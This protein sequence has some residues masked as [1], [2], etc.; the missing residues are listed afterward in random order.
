VFIIN[1]ND[2]V[3]EIGGG[4]NPR[5]R[6]NL[7]IRPGPYTDI[8]ADLNSR[9]PIEDGSYDVV[10]SQY[11]I[12]HVSWRNI[13]NL[14]AELY[15]VL[16]DNGRICLITA[17]LLEQCKVITELEDLDDKHVCMLFGRPMLISAGFRLVQ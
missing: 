17:N 3:L 12:E 13:D 8:V 2:R 10:F 15:R 4:D 11:M 6:P 7:D 5:Y 16:A 1:Q 9:F 14:I